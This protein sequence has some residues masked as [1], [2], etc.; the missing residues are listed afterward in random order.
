MIQILANCKNLNFKT[1]TFLLA[2]RKN[3]KRNFLYEIKLHYFEFKPKILTEIFLKY[4]LEYFSE[5]Y[6]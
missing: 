5:I 4:R 3:Y 1:T 2:L 6:S